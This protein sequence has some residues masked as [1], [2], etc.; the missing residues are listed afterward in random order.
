MSEAIESLKKR[1]AI[2]ERLGVKPIV[3]AI[4]T[5]TV[6]SGSTMEPEVVQAMVDASHVMVKIQELNERAGELIAKYTHAEAGL[7]T[8]GAADAM[9]LQATACIAGKDRAKIKRLPDTEGM[10]NEIIISLKHEENPFVH[11]WRGAGAKMVWVGSHANDVHNVRGEEIEAAIN[12]KSAALAFLA[13][14]V[15]PD[16]FDPLDEMVKV[17]QRYSLP[18]IVDAAAMLPPVENLWRFIDHGADMV[19]FSGGKMIWGP[20]STGIL[21]GRRDLI[22]AAALNHSPNMA[23]GRVAKVCKE[24]IIGLMVALERYVQRDHAADQR[25]WHEQCNTMAAALADIRGVKISVLQDDWT[26]PVPQL[27]IHLTSDWVGPSPDEIVDTMAKGDPPIIIGGSQQRQWKEQ[28]FVNPCVL[29]EGEA[30][31]VGQRLRTA[32][33]ERGGGQDSN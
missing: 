2:Y 24:E 21:C 33:V 10:K 32:M 29:V 19:A 26:Q 11:A 9:L 7:V 30:E 25:R 14:S 20:Q 13:T 27:S 16:S 28:L 31:L 4:G 22:E 6:Y 5:Y 18:V 1:G 8:A 12:E 23:I 17:A 15:A 3:S